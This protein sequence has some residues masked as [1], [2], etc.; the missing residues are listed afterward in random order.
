MID[1]VRIFDR[2][3]LAQSLQRYMLF[4]QQMPATLNALTNK[5]KI[6]CVSLTPE[7]LFVAGCGYEDCTMRGSFAVSH[8]EAEEK[9]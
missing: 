9:T 5:N 2:L 8:P 4:I 3:Q 7:H 1:N 6:K